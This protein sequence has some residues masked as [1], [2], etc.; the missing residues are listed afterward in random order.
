MLKGV[1]RLTGADVGVATTGIAGPDGGT[2]EKPVGTVWICVGT[3]DHQEA[4]MMRFSFDRD[5]NKM[6]SAKTALFML[7][8]LIHDQDI[9]R[10]DHS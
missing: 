4:R 6:I 7:R 1:L 2:A 8:N 3:A 10:T 9:H 5:G